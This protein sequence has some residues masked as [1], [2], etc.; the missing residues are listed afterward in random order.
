MGSSARSV[1]RAREEA[2]LE[3]EVTHTHRRCFRVV[4]A[5]MSIK[6]SHAENHAV[7]QKRAYAP[8]ALQLLV[9]EQSLLYI[10][11]VVSVIEQNSSQ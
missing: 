4:G 1:L 3:M 11:S 5:R 9:A 7:F 10:L 8:E 6:G 2:Y